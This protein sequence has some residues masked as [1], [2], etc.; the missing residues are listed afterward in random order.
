MKN[1]W[2]SFKDSITLL[3]S[4]NSANHNVRV[5][6]NGSLEVFSNIHD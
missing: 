2:V 4:T 1:L 6:V 3:Q 5:R